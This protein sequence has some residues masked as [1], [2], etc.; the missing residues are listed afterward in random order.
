MEKWKYRVKKIAAILLTLTL[1]LGAVDLS[2]F[3]VNA[4]ENYGTLI[5]GGETGECQ[6]AVYDSNGDETGD[7]MI[8]SG[9][10]SMGERV[11]DPPAMQNV[12]LPWEKYRETINAV[13]VEEGV[14]T[15]IDGAFQEFMSVSSITLP[16]SLTS[17][18][19]GA[20]MCSITHLRIPA[21]VKRIG[22]SAFYGTRITSI[23]IPEGVTTIENCAFH[24]T[25]LKSVKL[26]KSVTNIAEYAFAYSLDL[27]SIEIP[28][29]VKNIGEGA[30]AWCESLTSIKIP[31]GVTDIFDRTFENCSS[32]TSVELPDSVTSIGNYAFKDCSNLVSL[33]MPKDVT[34]IG[35]SAFSGCSSLTSMK[36]PEGI[37]MI[38]SETFKDCINLGSVEI[39]DSVTDF[40]DSAFANCSSL[41]T[42]ILPENVTRVG[43]YQFNDCK[44][45]NKIIYKGIKIPT[46][47][48][49]F[50]NTASDLTAYVC[51]DST[52]YDKLSGYG[53][54]NITISL[55]GVDIKAQPTSQDTILG[56]R[57]SFSVVAEGSIGEEN[58]PLGYQWQK[59]ESD[60]SWQD[61]PGA[62]S[63]SYQIASVVQA[64][65]GKYRCAMT[66][67]LPEILLTYSKLSEESELIIGKAM[68]YIMERPTVAAITYGQKI[69]DSV[70]EGGKV[71]Y[72][73][74]S[75]VEGFDTPVEGNFVWSSEETE[76][77]PFVADSNQA[78]YRVIFQPTDST[79]Y[80]EA[81]TTVKITV[82]KAPSAPGMPKTAMNVSKDCTKV[83][84]V[85]LPEGWTWQL[86]DAEKEL[87]TAI[88]LMATAE[89]SG[90]DRGNYEIESVEIA[91]TRSACNHEGGTATCITHAVCDLCG[92][93][94]GSLDSDNH[95]KTEV[96]NVQEATCTQ[97]GYTGDVCCTACGE[98]MS[99]GT[100]IVSLGHKGGTATCAHRA[101]CDV[102][103]QEYGELDNNHNHTE[104]RNVKAV[105]CT[106]DGYT[107]DT[108]CNDCGNKTV[109]GTIIKAQWHDYSSEVVREPSCTEAGE[110]VFS[111][112]CGDNYSES[113]AATGHQH[114]KIRDKVI[115]TCVKDGYTGDT[116][117]KDCDTKIA[118]GTV[119]K[120]VGHHY[121]SNITKKPTC[122]EE[123]IRTYYCS[124]GDRYTEIEPA[125]DHPQWELRGQKAATCTR[126]GYTGD[127]FCIACDLKMESGESIKELGHIY[128][129]KETKKATR[130]EEGIR[131]YTCT[132]CKD[133]YTKSIPK[134]SKPKKGSIIKWGRST[135][136]VIISDDKKGTVEHI[137]WNDNLSKKLDIPDVINIDG[138]K[139]KVTSISAKNIKGNN[140]IEEL[141]IGNNVTTICSD[142]FSGCKKLTTVTLG[143]K[144][145]TIGKNAFSGCINLKTL[146]MGA[147]VTTI[148]EKA[149]Y[150]C[151]AL[152]KITI[153]AKVNKIGKQALQGCKKLK[154]ITIKTAKLTSKNVGTKAFKG[155]HAKATVK[156]PKSK[157]KAYRKL[158]KAKGIGSKVKVCK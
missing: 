111:C 37:T 55:Y 96:R 127:Y 118:Q 50:S 45:L 57:V 108:Y 19:A 116:Y 40:G 158:L 105:T 115:A 97:E 100:I 68:P 138:A 15:I 29:G 144:V 2:A 106:E 101:V 58:K 78:E 61:I 7:L 38:G 157:V 99:R 79:R 16:E 107:G 70:L 149:F 130:F 71:Q 152:T 113:I 122:T 147:N 34:S 39:P 48:N 154:T 146:K 30:F 104:V 95:G 110:R 102:C 119:K 1:I 126:K 145:K 117:C 84:D 128:T 121:A 82:N 69:G 137:Q 125:L 21:G 151:T 80:Q 103:G 51:K 44:K 64:D 14:T 135:Y 136:R 153:P 24:G 72:S 49:M 41:T 60:G 62:N 90:A 20:F 129:S 8:I 112:S 18:G 134:P 133:S 156:V 140:H 132:R 66:I 43:S 26:P 67:E 77:R 150:Q 31:E 94:Y 142:A 36:I 56:N 28:E 65:A 59:Q 83:S 54:K 91:V 42:V 11:W 76:K 141:I 9:E 155:I 46:G 47:Y 131:T 27:T 89:Y 23:E 123:G 32:L 63:E 148:N 25:A 74:D 17:I 143:K 5:E 109:T 114:T 10:G 75:N 85:L 86:S 52:G 4:A 98:V 35:E 139:Y 3:S 81:E 120:A 87:E 73:S 13:V 22:E 93:E 124:C 33:E 92:Q 88:P 6:W 53:N 12:P